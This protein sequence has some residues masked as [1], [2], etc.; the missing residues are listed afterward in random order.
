MK[1]TVKTRNGHRDTAV[2]LRFSSLLNAHSAC[3]SERGDDGALFS[4]PLPFFPLFEPLIF[5][6]MHINPKKNS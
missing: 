2:A 6:P 5:L 1:L 4:S 3:P